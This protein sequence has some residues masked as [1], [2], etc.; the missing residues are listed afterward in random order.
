VEKQ[1]LGI[2][3]WG[4]EHAFWR[5]VKCAMRKHRGGSVQAVQVEPEDGDLIEFT[6]QAEVHE[7]IWSN[8]H[9]KQFYL[10]EEAPICNGPLRDEF[11]YNIDSEVGEEVLEGAYRFGA[12]FD[13]HTKDIL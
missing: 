9:Q 3:N 2:I 4:S 6:M 8:I 12:D 1:I 13:E 7:A 10:A 11:G 5:R